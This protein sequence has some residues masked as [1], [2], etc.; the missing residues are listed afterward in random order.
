MINPSASTAMLNKE[1]NLLLIEDNPAEARLFRELLHEVTGNR[2]TMSV[3]DRM[4]SALQV[5][6]GQ[7]FDA[8]LLDLS[9]PDSYG[10]A[11]LREVLG[12]IPAVP[13]VVL[14]GLDDGDLAMQAVSLGAQDYL[15]KGQVDGLLL[16]RS[17]RYAIE[18]KEAESALRRSEERFRR[19]FDDA[20]IGMVLVDTDQRFKDANKAFGAM[21]GYSRE[22]LLGMSFA[23]VTHPRD[24][25]GDRL[26]AQRRFTGEEDPP[27]KLTRQFLKKSRESVWV[28]I[29]ASS[30]RDE[31]GRVIYGVG[32]F[33]DLTQRREIE[34]QLRQS[35]KL[36]AI[37]RLAGGVAHDFNNLL[38]VIL[39]YS[40]MLIEML[41][42]E[43]PRR[44]TAGEIRKAG[45]RASSLTRQLLAFS[46]SQV[47]EP[48]VLDLNAVVENTDRLLRR[49][50]GE[51]VALT[52]RLEPEL[53]RIEADVAQLEQVILNLAVNARDAMPKGGEL[54]IV[55][56]NV[57]IGEEEAALREPQPAGDY[58]MLRIRDTGE[59]MNAE[60]KTRIF[61]PF[62]TTKEEG[63]GTGLGL[64]TVY[65]IVN[66]TG[67]FIRVE[68]EPGSGAT[69]RIYLPRVYK[70]LTAS[71]G[72][73]I[74]GGRAGGTETLILV[75]DQEEVLDLATAVLRDRGYTVLKAAGGAEAI[76]VCAAH[77]GPI[78][79][80]ITDVVMPGMNGRQLAERLAQSYPDL[81]VL[82]ISGYTNDAVVRRGFLES[83]LRFLQK[84]FTGNVLAQRVRDV[85]DG[86]SGSVAAGSSQASL[87]AAPQT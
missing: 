40:E 59:G 78:D 46:R 35:H 67:G 76:E 81:K 11:T 34:A 56:A 9:L 53:G 31:T 54:E 83:G 66:Q 12:R 30:I 47:L 58:V 84:P 17:L 20:P 69:F 32:M 49:L 25:E 65:G 70:T 60:T 72:F 7:A 15:V 45:V 14:T 39:G 61:E 28:E 37:G 27:R 55:T 19:A 77:D 43:D 75:E 10:L 23:D 57:R 63:K 33:E 36:E 4:S 22:E 1:L 41:G 16:A 79:L 6:D 2:W 62:F 68:S 8:V 74:T 50:I 48:R 86:G 42:S 26:L 51:D 5:L 38:T 80:L 18:R 52:I 24:A 13:I 44:Q 64:A 3:A 21:L 87:E 71:T 29:T 73:T 85:M 82:Y